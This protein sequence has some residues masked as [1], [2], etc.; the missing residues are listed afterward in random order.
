M[1]RRQR[2]DHQRRLRK[3]DNAIR[4]VMAASEADG[5]PWHVYGM[6]SACRDCGAT[7]DFHGHGRTGM[8]FADIY[9]DDGCPAAAGI[10]QWQP[11]PIH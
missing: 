8:V 6:T 9:H 5:R 3:V 10:T 2:R 11:H 7:A 1:N 4:T